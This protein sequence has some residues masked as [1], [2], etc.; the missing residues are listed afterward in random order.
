MYFGNYGFRKKL[1]DKSL[2]S[3]VLEDPWKCKMVNGIKQC[4]NMN[5]TTF[6]V[7]IDHCEGN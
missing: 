6:T 2:K 1:L 7:F 3:R 5:D 4:W